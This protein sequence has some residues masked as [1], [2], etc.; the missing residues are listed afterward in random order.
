MSLLKSICPNHNISV[1]AEIRGDR[2]A[3][4]S[5]VDPADLVSLEALDMTAPEEEIIP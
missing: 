2:V 1:M 3:E 4:Q 5:V